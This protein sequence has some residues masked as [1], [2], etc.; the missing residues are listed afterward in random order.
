MQESN[1]NLN[2]TI[3][4]W[5]FIKTLLLS[6]GM[7]A[8]LLTGLAFLM[9]QMKLGAAQA[10]WGVTVIYLLA[11][12]VGGFLTGKRVGSRRLLWGLVSGGLYFVILWMLSLILGGGMQ[13]EMQELLTALAACLAGSAVGAFLS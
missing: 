3:H 6:Y 1:T 5:N 9:Y 7:T 13:G 8:V 11:C 10:S 4:P 12:A 2:T